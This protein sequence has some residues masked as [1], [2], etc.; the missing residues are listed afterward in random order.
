MYQTAVG[1]CVGLVIKIKLQALTSYHRSE[2]SHLELEM[3]AFEYGK[4]SKNHSLYFMDIGGP[5]YLLIL[6]SADFDFLYMG[7]SCIDVKAENST[8]YHAVHSHLCH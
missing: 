4:L 6:L 3:V 1:S 5:C 2:W 8:M 7:R